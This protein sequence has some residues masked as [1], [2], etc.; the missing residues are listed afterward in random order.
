[1]PLLPGLAVYRA[2]YL[3]QEG[4]PAVVPNALTHLLTAVATGIALAGGLSIGG[5]LARRR[6]G[7]DVAAQR[8][9]KRSRG[10]VVEP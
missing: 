8:A 2:I 10:R 3:M 5:Y 1:V 7:L 9:R 6:L 4:T